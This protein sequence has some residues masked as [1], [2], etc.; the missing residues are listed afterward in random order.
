V[1]DL[2]LVTQYF[3]M[4]KDLGKKNSKSTLF[5]PHGPKSVSILRDQLKA[6]FMT[7]LNPV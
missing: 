2:L 7:G 4:L 1:M 3:D 6:G 5:L